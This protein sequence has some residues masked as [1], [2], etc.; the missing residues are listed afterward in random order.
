MVELRVSEKIGKKQVSYDDILSS[1]QMCID[2]STGKIKI[3]RGDS[4]IQNNTK[5][6]FNSNYNP[7]TFNTNVNTNVK[8]NVK[9]TV[10]SNIN[11]NI[12]PT[13]KSN[14]NPTVKSNI[15][16]NV[17]SNVNPNV[18]SNVKSNIN[19]IKSILKTSKNFMDPYYSGKH[20]PLTAPIATISPHISDMYSKPF[21]EELEELGEE[22]LGE[23]ELGEDEL[24]EDESEE[25][26]QEQE[27]RKQINLYKNQ[28][29]L[30]KIHHHNATVRTNQIKTKKLLFAINN[31]NIGFSHNSPLNPLNQ[32]FKLNR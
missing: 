5:S 20:T 15:N 31:D 29:L 26:K 27:R 1:M 14:I 16:P 32:L 4:D 3:K 12:N 24:G 22:E 2:P 10:K 23:D 9:S 11:P 13:V 21:Q 19:P 6:Y 8:S 28:I 7:N 17:K 18:K 30:Q 25:L